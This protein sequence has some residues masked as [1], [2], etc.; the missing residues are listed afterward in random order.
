MSAPTFVGVDVSKL[1]LDVAIR[2]SG[3]LWQFGYDD[4]YYDPRGRTIYAKLNF[5]F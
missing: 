1:L 4:R 2:P 5:R 3:E